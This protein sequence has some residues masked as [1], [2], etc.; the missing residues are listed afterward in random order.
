MKVVGVFR[1]IA[2]A[3]LCSVH[4]VGKWHSVARRTVSS[5]RLLAAKPVR[6]SESERQSLLPALKDWTPAKNRDGIE[7]TFMFGSFV[8]AFGFMTQVALLAEKHD[9]HPEWFNVYNKVNIFLST[10]DCDGLSKRDT[11]LAKLIDDVFARSS[12]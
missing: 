9:H 1:L 5:T 12:K 8:Q 10:H 6:L 2:G 3:A 7:R 11:D 4:V